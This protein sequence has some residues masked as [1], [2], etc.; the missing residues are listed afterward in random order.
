[1][2][3]PACG[4]NIPTPGLRCS[5]C[6]TE[7]PRTKGGTVVIDDGPTPGQAPQAPV[8]APH[9]PAAHQARSQPVVASPVDPFAHTAYSSRESEAAMAPQPLPTGQVEETAAAGWQL[10][11]PETRSGLVVRSFVG[12]F[13]LMLGTPLLVFAL[14]WLSYALFIDS[15]AVSLAII[16][17]GVTALVISVLEI[18]AGTRVLKG[19]PSPHLTYVV[20]LVAQ[21][22]LTLTTIV[23]L[24]ISARRADGLLP[25]AFIIFFPA[26][27]P[28]LRL[29]PLFIRSSG[30]LIGSRDL[31]PGI[32]VRPVPFVLWAPT[33]TLLASP[34][35]VL[36][37]LVAIFVMVVAWVSPPQGSYALAGAV[38]TVAL[39]SCVT[40]VGVL[41]SS[42]AL[43]RRSAWATAAGGISGA[44]GTL[45]SAVLLGVFVYVLI[46]EDGVDPDSMAALTYAILAMTAL[47]VP[48]LSLVIGAFRFR[49]RQ[50]DYLEAASPSDKLLHVLVP[51]EP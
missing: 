49:F 38:S 42:L 19:S 39:V 31:G 43:F 35:L 27:I 21:V 17:F 45:L 5:R 7:L 22:L 29:A 8:Y 26:F 13:S 9:S 20:A 12:C 44:I 33:T 41:V 2:F 24:A 15:R 47:V 3:C 28:L 51:T 37:A 25:L 32:P 4:L 30:T 11:A 34:M 40:C 36:S 14:L 6:G 16:L 48:S 10:P 18:V 46:V 1:M 23:V 50:P